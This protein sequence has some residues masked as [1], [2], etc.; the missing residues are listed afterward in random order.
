MASPPRPPAPANPPTGGR[1]RVP[2]GA[3][4]GALHERQGY[5]YALLAGLIVIWGIN[6]PIMKIGLQDISPFWFAFMRTSWAVP[7][8]FAAL[9]I[10]GEL[11]LPPRQDLPVIISVGVFQI[12]CFLALVNIGLQYVTS[13]EAAV[14]CYSTPIWVTPAAIFLLGERPTP[15]KVLGLLAGIA[16]VFVLFT[17]AVLGELTGEAVFG[18][19]LLMLAAFIWAFVILHVRAHKWA[20]GPLR[21]APWQLSAAALVLL[22]PS[23]IFEDAG[24]IRWTGDLWLVLLYN[25]PIA[26]ALAYWAAISVTRALP[27]I[28]TSLVMLGVPALGIVSGIVVLGEP[29]TVW[30]AAG[31]TLIFL[32]V[33]LVAIAD[34]RARTA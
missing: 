28:S 2:H 29:V 15:L 20:S 3:S 34:Q 24:A 33:A 5:G 22:P 19:G 30:L 16:G 17:P 10:R 26:S 4:T 18:M 27:A 9:V 12:G 11:R 31:V 7:V 6:W 32:G 21:V 25:G 8:L 14:L 23:L 13:G 1:S